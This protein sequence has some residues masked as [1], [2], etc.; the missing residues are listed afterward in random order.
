VSKIKTE[1]GLELAAYQPRFI[2]DQIVA[3]CRFMEQPPHLEPRYVGYALDN[4]RVHRS[5]P[6]PAAHQPHPNHP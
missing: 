2:V 3:S 6:P 5:S 1:K 4:L